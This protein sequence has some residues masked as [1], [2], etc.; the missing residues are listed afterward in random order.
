MIEIIVSMFI[1]SRMI[2]EFS[3]IMEASKPSCKFSKHYA[4]YE[5]IGMIKSILHT[6]YGQNPTGQNPTL[7]KPHRT[8]PHWTKPHPQPD[9]TPLHS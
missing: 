1:K 6:V 5:D 2:F 9:K 4:Y 8:K 3:F 7:T